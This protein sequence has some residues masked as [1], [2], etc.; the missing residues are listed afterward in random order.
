MDF[1]NYHPIRD[2][3][4]DYRN[5]RCYSR[6]FL[7]FRN[8]N[9]L[10]NEFIAFLHC[11]AQT[12]RAESACARLCPATELVGAQVALLRCPI[13]P[14]S[15]AIVLPCAAKQYKLLRFDEACGTKEVCYL[16][17]INCGGCSLACTAKHS[18]SAGSSNQ[19]SARRSW[20]TISRRAGKHNSGWASRSTSPNNWA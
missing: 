12:Q 13:L 5:N 9:I 18:G 4:F 11:R 10:K 2:N 7:D 6:A 16:E 14:A 15:A 20:A 1:Q 8:L 3:Y 19:P 17:I